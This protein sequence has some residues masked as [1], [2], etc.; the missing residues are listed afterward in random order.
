M[1]PVRRALVALLACACLAGTAAGSDGLGPQLDPNR[2]SKLPREGLVVQ[3][4]SRLVLATARGR[5]LGHL[6]RFSLVGDPGL[7]Q[8]APGA[9][10][11]VLADRVGDR[12]ELRR[13]RLVES[14][15]TL[16]LA[17]GAH[18][19][20]RVRGRWT[21]R[22]SRVGFVSERRDLVTFFARRSAR[23]LDVRSG[24]SVSIPFG[25]RAAARV[26]ARWFLLCGYPFGDPKA[27]ST[28]QVREADGTLRK[29][30]G[31]AEVVAGA[32]P[33]GWWAYAFLSPSGSRLLLQWSGECEIPVAFLGATSGGSLRTVT[34]E[35][36]LVNAPE[37]VAFGW[38][39]ARALVDLPKGACG[40]S[41]SRP[42]VYLVDPATLKLTYVFRHSRFWRSLS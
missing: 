21:F 39:G 19:A 12:W 22:G 7:D 26:G 6:D 37:S 18:L 4:G 1:R 3:V 14:D 32:R 33:A 41:A 9:R 8:L 27:A 2:L 13:G 11:L 38:S 36:G 29:L 15:G 30:F 16:Q 42:G 24:R 17:N 20:Q 28:V 34:G 31:P 5:L 25:C 10:P 23:V 35:P 40:E